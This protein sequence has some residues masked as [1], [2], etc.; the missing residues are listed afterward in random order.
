[1]GIVKKIKKALNTETLLNKRS[2]LIHDYEEISSF[3]NTEEY[4]E[5]VELKDVV[6]SENFLKNKTKI[7]KLRYKGSDIFNDEK[8]WNKLKNNKKIKIFHNV[9][10]SLILKDYISFSGSEL[11]IQINDLKKIDKKNLSKED[12]VRL[13]RYLEDEKIRRYYKFESSKDYKRYKQVENSV[14]LRE[15]YNI[16]KR[17]ESSEF[18]EQKAFL[19]NTRRYETTQ[20]YLL[21][22]RYEELLN[23]SI[24]RKYLKYKDSSEFD[25]IKDWEL[26]FEN[27]FSDGHLDNSKWSCVLNNIMESNF[28]YPED[29]HYFTSG[30]NI[31]LQGNNLSLQTRKENTEGIVLDPILGFIK[32]NFEYSSAALSTRGNFAQKYGKFEAKIKIGDMSLSQTFW[33]SGEN[34]F[35]H[36][37]II[38][39]ISNKKST[40]SLISSNSLK[41]NL[42]IKKLDLSNDYYIY[43]LIWQ[44]N[45][46]E[47]RINDILVWSQEENIPSEPM[48]LNFASCVYKDISTVNSKMNIDWVRVYK[49]VE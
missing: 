14:L 15:Y 1:M 5:Y 11:N 21:L 30:E 24:V 48:S 19:L 31:I 29:K 41:N 40:V 36:I 26:T 8:Q 39:S 34:G 10:S 6:T 32:K 49:M 27:G 28:S 45:K 22:K 3:L 18:K 38:K 2:E 44:P 13:S 12:R 9:E 16:K 17:V 37:D 43:T 42:E 46:I 35:P 20:D 47:W 25:F 7:E 23:S 33:L 4:R